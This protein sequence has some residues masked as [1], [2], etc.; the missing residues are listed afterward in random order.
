MTEHNHSLSDTVMRDLV[1]LSIHSSKRAAGALLSVA[2]LFSCG[3]SLPLPNNVD[4]SVASS[5]WPGASLNQLQA[6]RRTVL[7]R[8]GT[9]HSL[10]SPT[11]LPKHAWEE[12]V[13]RMRNKNGAKIDD[14]E[15]ANITRY[16]YAMASR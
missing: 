10:K 9:C 14:E 7:A 2:A 15:A 6:G 12:T 5:R 4:V 1:R 11:S 16:L 3:A 13:N 8:C